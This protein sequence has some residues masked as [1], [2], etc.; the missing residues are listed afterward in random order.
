MSTVS[1]R[2]GPRKASI[3]SV[4][5][6]PEMSTVEWSATWA[7]GG[8]PDAALLRRANATSRT[9][10]SGS[11]ESSGVRRAAVDALDEAAAVQGR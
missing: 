11:S 5:V 10:R 2:T 9:G 8:L 1:P 7:R 4:V 6:P 3:A